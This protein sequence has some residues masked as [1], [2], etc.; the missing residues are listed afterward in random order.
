[1]KQI[2]ALRKQNVTGPILVVMP[3]ALVLVLAQLDF[4]YAEAGSSGPSSGNVQ[5]RDELHIKLTS[6][7]FMPNAV[8]HAAGTFAIAVENSTMSGDYTLRLKAHDGTVLKEVAVQKGSSAWTVSL[9]A[10]KYTITEI[11]NPNWICNLTVH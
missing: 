11:N 1:M 3:L 2:P 9:G 10:G 8:Q 6:S 5:S 4:P 7:G